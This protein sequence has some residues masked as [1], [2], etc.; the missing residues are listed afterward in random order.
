MRIDNHFFNRT[1]LIA[2]FVSLAGIIWF[3]LGL[4]D[5][6]IETFQEEFLDTQKWNSNHFRLIGS[7]DSTLFKNVNKPAVV[8]FWA[9]W[10]GLSTDGL[11][12]LAN[13]LPDSIHIYA[14]VVKDNEAALDVM[15]TATT[16]RVHFIYGTYWYLHNQVPAVPTL[17]YIDKE[18][19]IRDIEVGYRN[20]DELQEVLKTWI[21]NP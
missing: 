16:N 12:E 20:Q 8:Y 15:D 10:S 21:R 18:S 6:R 4:T 11:K 9:A 5:E 2:A 17:M 3:S 7:N 13:T 19:Y 14:A 1:I